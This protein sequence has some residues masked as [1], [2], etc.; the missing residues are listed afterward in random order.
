VQNNILATY[1][2]C[3][4]LVIGGAGLTYQ[5]ISAQGP[6]DTTASSSLLVEASQIPSSRSSAWPPEG[7]AA[8]VAFYDE[9]MQLLAPKPQPVATN[10][11]TVGAANDTSQA[12]PAR[13]TRTGGAPDGMRNKGDRARYGNN[14]RRR[15][16]DGRMDR[17]RAPPDVVDDNEARDPREAYGRADEDRS[18][19]RRG[20][21][22]RR[23]RNWDERDADV[24][25][26]RRPSP[27]PFFGIFGR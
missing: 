16:T 15:G 7:D 10:D 24:I 5:S 17:R 25:I 19:D 22:G 23:D 3:L 27:V 1:L 4:G 8:A 20:R 9:W 21:D 2:G 18:R 11:V 6:K 12:P 26:E 13:T 14:D